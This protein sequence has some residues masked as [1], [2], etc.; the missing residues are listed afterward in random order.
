M[1]LN[2]QLRQI[3][4]DNFDDALKIT[5]REMIPALVTLPSVTAFYWGYHRLK[6]EPVRAV[7]LGAGGQGR[8]HIDSINPDYI[9]LVAFSDIRPSAQKK[10]RLSLQAKYGSAARDIELVEDYRKLLDRDDVEMVIN[11]LPLHLHAPV[12][13]EAMEKGKHVL[14]EK[15]MAKTVMD[16]K[17]MARAASR[18]GK[19]LSIGHQRHYSYLYANALEVT[20]QKDILGDVRHIRA[21]W[22][23]NQTG[24]GKPGA[25]KGGFDT[26]FINVPAEDR[27]IDYA[28]HG[29]ASIEELV[30]WRLFHRTGAGLMAE[31]GSHQLDA[32]SILLKAVLDGDAKQNRALHP[33]AVS[34]VGVN[35]FFTDG[36]E[37]EDH[38]FLTYEYPRDV[39][40][41]YSSITTNE[42]DSYGEQVMGT[43]GTLAILAE[44]DVF[45]FKEKSLKDTR[46][47]WAER[48]IAQPSAVSTSTTQWTT[49]AGLQDTLTS[50]GYREEQEH[51]AWLIRNPG[52]GQP[53]CNP[54]IGLADAV[55]TLVSNM[56]ASQRR[57]IEFKPSWFDIRSDEVPESQS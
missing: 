41:S 34:G 47:T 12:S 22:H 33:A 3:G 27:K 55:V 4:R 8:S 35:S 31:L 26:W 18:T 49:G 28:R 51:L 5:R 16:C 15:L 19:L 2:D 25:E 53:R 56:A 39:V 46:I 45:L 21:F 57:R 24:G 17:R 10:A 48:R 50:R 29:Y 6:G 13:I 14:C 23:R 42:M 11:A 32:C 44:K 43:R 38:V 40:V 37:V 1:V 36:R 30:R 7:L 54:E 9:K 20:R 52:T